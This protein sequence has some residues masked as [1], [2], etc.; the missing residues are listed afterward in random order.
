M[1]D[2]R[3]IDVSVVDADA[4]TDDETSEEDDE[5]DG[6]IGSSITTKRERPRSA[7]ES[8]QSVLIRMF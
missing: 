5:C 4:A 1:C 7:T 6:L 3:E 8:W 2:T